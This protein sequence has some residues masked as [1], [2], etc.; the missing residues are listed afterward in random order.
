MLTETSETYLFRS[1]PLRSG[2]LEQLFQN[3]TGLLQ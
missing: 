1:L 2:M 3:V